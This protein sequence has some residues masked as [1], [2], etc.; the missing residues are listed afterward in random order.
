MTNNSKVNISLEID[1]KIDELIVKN[2][3]KDMVGLKIQADLNISN[4]IIKISIISIIYSMLLF[5]KPLN[6]GLLLYSIILIVLPF[7]VLA[8]II[9][10]KNS[11]LKYSSNLA[12]TIIYILGFYI[13]TCLLTFTVLVLLK[14]THIDFFNRINA[15]VYFIPIFGILFILTLFWVFLHQGFKRENELT[16]FYFVLINILVVNSLCLLIYLKISLEFSS[17]GWVHILGFSALLYGVNLVL[18]STYF[19]SKPFSSF[20]CTEFNS[21]KSEDSLVIVFDI[22]LNMC[23]ICFLCLLGLYLDNKLEK[24]KLNA[25]FV[26]LWVFFSLI[27]VKASYKNKKIQNYFEWKKMVII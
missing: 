10:F 2:I 25:L 15:F 21:T 7:L 22:L 18:F 1:K 6:L 27:C 5:F 8:I 12:K 9:E 4:S 19:S 24:I 16:F 26:L 3:H 13:F 23:V 14:L 20:G 17:V 11:Y